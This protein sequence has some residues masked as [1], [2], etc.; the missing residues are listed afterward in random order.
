[1]NASQEPAGASA[2]TSAG[3]RAG[4]RAPKGAGD[5]GGGEAGSTD[6][7]RAPAPR[8]R[9]A[10]SPA[11]IPW[12]A[13]RWTHPPVRAHE[14][15]DGLRAEAAEGSDAWRLTSY[16][17]IHDS[18]HALVTDFAAGGGMEVTFRA[19]FCQQFDQAGIFLRVD[20]LR[21]IKAGVEYADG[22]L[23]VGAVVTDGFSDWSVVPVPQWNGGAITLRLSWSGDA[24]TIR[25]RRDE[26][27]W[28]LVRVTHLPDDLPA[29]AGPYLCAPT[30]AGLEVTFT[31]WC[32][33]K[34]DAG[35]H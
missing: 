19:D 16:G 35:L 17:F 28:R 12:Q 6:A 10:H 1:M 3:T 33:A 29:E 31:S 14:G 15:P 21:W 26:E 23:Q 32:L 25:A 8:P 34:A 22:A 30:R 9:D 4:G 5:A 18:E 13:G 27:D 2:H 11:Q 24:V 20:E 7:A